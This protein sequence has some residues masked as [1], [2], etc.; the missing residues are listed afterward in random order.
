MLWLAAY[1]PQWVFQYLRYHHDLQSVQ[2]CLLFEP[3][4]LRVLAQ[5]EIAEQVGIGRGMS[6]STAQSLLPDVVLVE[7][8]PGLCQQA[9]DWLCQWSYAFSARVVPLHCALM[10]PPYTTSNSKF[11]VTDSVSDCL[12]LEVS[13]MAR[14]FGGLD[15]LV[16]QYAQKAQSLG[17]E[18]QLAIANTPLGAQLLALQAPK[19]S[20]LKTEAL[21]ERNEQD[22]AVLC[23]KKEGIL[24]R[25][26]VVN[27]A[28]LNQEKLSNTVIAQ[29]SFTQTL[30]MQSRYLQHE[31]SRHLLASLPISR[32]PISAYLIE[33]FTNI[34]LV[35]LEDIMALP[36]KE[37]GQRFGQAL[38]QMLAKI[39]GKLPQPMVYFEPAEHYR[40]KLSLLYEVESMPG[41]IFP[42]RRMIN[43]MAD[44]LLLRQLAVQT[45]NLTFRYRDLEL[46]PLQIVIHYPFAEHR[47][48]ALL[49]LCHM[50]LARMTLYQPIVE[51]IISADKFVPLTLGQ[52]AWLSEGAQ[53]G[54]R[55]RLLSQLQARLGSDKIKGLRSVPSQLPEQSWQSVEL[56]CYPSIQAKA[57]ATAEMII[58]ACR[59]L[60][61]LE[62]P[63]ALSLAEFE[64][65]K[66][67]ERLQSH[68]WQDE[69][70]CRDYYIASHI[71]GGL[72]WVYRDQQGFYLH[73]WFA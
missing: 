31:Q 20:P 13:S 65:I 55:Q 66:G 1:Y 34:G 14:I 59:P 70:P 42:L 11:A 39:T 32:L 4:S 41:I 61:L 71:D 35:T 19:Y 62:Q 30:G 21:D 23:G 63:Q 3:D 2:G 24:V 47:A 29:T 68:W 46:A 51:I 57:T 60:W 56:T 38:L 33:T 8:E 6:I 52:E 12:L 45:L 27:P 54:A 5:D 40:Q 25:D 36:D 10:P 50:Q 53:S 49:S 22:P 28:P 69:S 67:P 9:S 37:L 7:F 43:E 48:E 44:Y 15:S 18:L 16:A 72:C 58:G 73:G 17:L 26:P 64:L